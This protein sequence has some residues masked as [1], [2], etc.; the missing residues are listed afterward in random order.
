MGRQ[1]ATRAET[2]FGPSVRVPLRSIGVFRDSALEE[3]Q[4]KFAR[5]A[6][7]PGDLGTLVT[8]ARESQACIRVHRGRATNLSARLK[9]PNN[10]R[11]EICPPA[12]GE[13]LADVAEVAAAPPAPGGQETSNFP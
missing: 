1:H 4:K 3:R 11:T 9:K 8:Q 12:G 13:L 7:I 2:K 6:L 10:L 5:I